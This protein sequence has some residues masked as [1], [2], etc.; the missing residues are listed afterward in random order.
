MLKN[1]GVYAKT[2]IT[3]LGGIV[4]AAAPYLAQYRWWPAVP[5][6]LTIISVYL[7]PNAPPVIDQPVTAPPVPQPVPQRPRPAAAPAA[8]PAEAVTAPLAKPEV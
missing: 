4:T 8:A 2:I 1:S 6:V 3:A 7:V 5:A